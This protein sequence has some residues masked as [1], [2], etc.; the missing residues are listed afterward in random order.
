MLDPANPL[1]IQI[2]IGELVGIPI[3]A[4]PA[5][6]SLPWRGRQLRWSDGSKMN[7]E[8]NPS[9]AVLN[10]IVTNIAPGSV[11]IARKDG[12]AIHPYHVE[13]LCKFAIAVTMGTEGQMA[14][15]AMQATATPASF[16]DFW[17]AFKK[18][19]KFVGVQSPY[20]V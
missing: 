17:K 5:M 2:T 12:K 7:P 13:A 1:L 19:K 10:P 14:W 8:L 11:V 16:E 9:L 20:K 4:I 3:M 6:P 18:D 15:S